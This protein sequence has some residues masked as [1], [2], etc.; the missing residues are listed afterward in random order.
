MESERE[1]QLISQLRN[2]SIISEESLDDTPN[3]PRQSVDEKLWRL[4]YLKVGGFDIH[5]WNEIHVLII[6]ANKITHRH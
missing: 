6:C 1:S 2:I 4:S 3:T 5:N